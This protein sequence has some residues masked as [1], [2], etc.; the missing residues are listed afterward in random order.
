MRKH[1][2][3]EDAYHFRPFDF[4]VPGSQITPEQDLVLI[5]FG[6]LS[7]L[8]NAFCAIKAGWELQLNVDV[9]GKLSQKH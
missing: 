1:T 7:M 6:S 9:S 5:T 2:D 3:P 4:V 8:I